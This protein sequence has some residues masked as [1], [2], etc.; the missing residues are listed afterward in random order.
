MLGSRSDLGRGCNGNASIVVL[1]DLGFHSYWVVFRETHVSS[2]FVNDLSERQKV[3]HGL[4]KTQY[5]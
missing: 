3:A 2:D 4:G 5:F 1:K